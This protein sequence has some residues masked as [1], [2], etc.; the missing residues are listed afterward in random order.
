[1]REVR[2]GKQVNP[3][4]PSSVTQSEIDAA[5]KS[6]TSANQAN[7]QGNKPA[8]KKPNTNTN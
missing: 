6:A 7:Q 5:L 8:T 4:D 3:F 2:S 1:M